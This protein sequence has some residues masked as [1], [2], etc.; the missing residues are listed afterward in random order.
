MS[1]AGNDPVPLLENLAAARERYTVFLTTWSDKDRIH[2]EGPVYAEIMFKADA[3]RVQQR[4]QNYIRSRGYGNWISVVTSPKGSYKEVDIL[5]FLECHIPAMCPG[6][7]WRCFMSDDF[8]PHKADNV[9]RCLWTKGYTS[10]NHGGGVT[11]VLQTNDTDQ[12]QHCRRDYVNLES[13]LFLRLQ[14]RGQRI[15]TPSYEQIIDM[16]VQV[17]QIKATH[18]ISADGFKKTGMTVA[19]DG[20]EDSC[21][22]REAKAYWLELGM[23]AQI[24][25]V[26]ATV[27]A[28]WKEKRLKWCYDDVRSLIMPFPKHSKHDQVLAS[29]EGDNKFPVVI[30]TWELIN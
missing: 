23:R 17:L 14:A 20:S 9:G 24:D 3:E 1:V 2:T 11:L 19:L 10:L 16:R 29:L 28:E 7:R 22:A 18:L 5:N 25:T 12:N 4:L 13:Q 30:I 8:A 6:R 21:V 27:R 26:V 15:P